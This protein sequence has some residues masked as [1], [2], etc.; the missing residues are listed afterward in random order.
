MEQP[1][2][3]CENAGMAD[4]NPGGGDVWL[5]SVVSFADDA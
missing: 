3:L 4:S 2:F 1:L 5:L